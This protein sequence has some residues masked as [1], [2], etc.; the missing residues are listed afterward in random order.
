MVFNHSYML[1]TLNNSIWMN[2]ATDTL[3]VLVSWWLWWQFQQFWLLKA[4]KNVLTQNFVF[5]VLFGHNLDPLDHWNPQNN[6]SNRVAK[7]TSRFTIKLSLHLILFSSCLYN[8]VASNYKNLWFSTLLYCYVFFYFYQNLK[9]WTRW[10]LVPFWLLGDFVCGPR[11][12][13]QHLWRIKG[14]R[15]PSELS[16]SF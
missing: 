9:N 14:R 6:F 11:G 16:V 10:D 2:I 15:H 4:P 12:S 8:G 5:T 1:C 3:P 13:F 7:S